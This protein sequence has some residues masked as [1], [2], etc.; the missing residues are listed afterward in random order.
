MSLKTELLLDIV[1]KYGSPVYVYDSAVIDRQFHRLNTALNIKNKKIHFA[2]KAL[3]NINILKI[4]RELGTGLDTVSIGEIHLGRMAGFK[5]EDIIYTPSSVSHQELD[6]AITFGVKINLDSI[7]ILKYIGQ[8]HKG[9]AVG[10]RFN[11]EIMAGG[12]ENISVGHIDSK[13]G[14]PISYLEEVKAIVDQYN[15]TINGIHIHTGS[16]IQDLEVFKEEADLLLE[17]AAH[18]PDIDYL[19]FGGGLKVKYR[20]D[21]KELDVTEFGTVISERFNQLCKERNKDIQFICEPGKFLVSEAGVFLAK[22]TLL[23]K[24]PNTLFVGVD[25]G[26]NHFARPILYGSYHMVDNLSNPTAEY[27][28]YT[29]VGNICEKDTFAEKRKI[30]KIRMGDIMCFRNAGAYGFSMSSNYNLRRK[31]AEVLI[32]HDQ[33]FLIREREKLEDILNAQKIIPGIFEADPVI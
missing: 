1:E 21:D 15:I 4:L 22:T 29:V 17:L 30:N 28:E 18:F 32:H 3:P 7:E 25:T 14:I 26:F 23:K 19:D 5:A 11:P 33:V 16:D 20:P 24:A 9:K 13:F 27:Q 12:N 8:K 31:P 10:L 6:E 2:C